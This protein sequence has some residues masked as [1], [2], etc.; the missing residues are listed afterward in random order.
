VIGARASVGEPPQL[1]ILSR[2][3]CSHR[4]DRKASLGAALLLSLVA[5]LI[6]APAGATRCPTWVKM[7]PDEKSATIASMIDRAVAGSGGRN[8]QIDRAAVGRCMDDQSR[9]IEFAFDNACSDSRSA[10]MQAL[11]R[12]FKDFVWSCVR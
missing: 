4:I 11:N 10:G 3:S 9:E 6:A 7:S 8:R 1:A 5:L 2:M 12:T